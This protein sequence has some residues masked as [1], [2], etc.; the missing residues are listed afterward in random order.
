MLSDVL[1]RAGWS[2]L[3][4][5]LISLTCCALIIFLS[6]RYPRLAGRP[7]DLC[8]VQ[9]AHHTLTPRLGG[10]GVFVALGASLFFLPDPVV[11]PFSVFLVATGILFAVGLAE[12]VGWHVT[13]AGRLT[14]AVIA[15]LVVMALFQVWVPRIG[16]GPLDPLMAHGLIGIPITL[17]AVAGIAN[18]FNL[19]DGVNGLAGFTACVASCAIA[20]VAYQAGSSDIVM[21][22]VF[23]AIS[24]LGFLVLNMPFG[25]IFLGD[26]GAYMLGFVLSWLGIAILVTNQSAT[27]WAI[28]LILFWPIADTM[29]AIYRRWL[30]HKNAMRP[31]RLHVHQLVMRVLEICW[32]GRNQRR[33]ANALTTPILAPFI[34]APTIFGAVLWDN[35]QWAF[36]TFWGFVGL[37]FASYFAA[38]WVLNSSLLRRR[39]HLQAEESPLPMVPPAE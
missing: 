35:P 38:G 13:P 9:S 24:V 31:D 12:D 14:A 2:A 25:R 39:R 30:H 37:F 15:C 16:F 7:S 22:A 23:L 20:V 8:S 3:V 19:I 5:F 21:V 4:L 28:T 10:I 1:G 36:L 32:L 33:L 29:L 27:P 17:L 26:A 34:I 18:S 6:R 11:F